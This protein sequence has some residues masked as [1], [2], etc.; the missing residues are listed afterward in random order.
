MGTADKTGRWSEEEDALAEKLFSEGVGR[1]QIALRLNRSV[2]SIDARRAYL[3][4]QRRNPRG[5][6][7]VLDGSLTQELDPEDPGQYG[8]EPPIAIGPDDPLLAKLKR[9]HGHEK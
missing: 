2:D 5:Y 9:V 8:D 7:K 1:R 3:A 4:G 6:S